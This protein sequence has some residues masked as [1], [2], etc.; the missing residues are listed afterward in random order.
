MESGCT[1]LDIMLYSDILFNSVLLKENQCI[2][3]I[4]K[5]N[6]SLSPFFILHFMLFP[7]YCNSFFHLQSRSLMYLIP[8]LWLLQYLTSV[9]LL[10]V[11]F[12]TSPSTTFL[13][14]SSICSCSDSN[15]QF[16]FSYMMSV[17]IRRLNKKDP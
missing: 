14:S 3:G 17:Q 6:K 11:V 5:Q 15:V 13:D 7:C 4:P 16:L 2:F 12:I 10:S 1:I 9:P 8:L